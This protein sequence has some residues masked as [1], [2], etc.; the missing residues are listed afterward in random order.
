MKNEKEV[1]ELTSNENSQEIDD[2]IWYDMRWRK[3]KLAM[4][5]AG[6]ENS[7]L[8]RMNCSVSLS[9]TRFILE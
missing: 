6:N 9:F 3:G 8:V 1:D 2:M 5:M 7:S 4:I